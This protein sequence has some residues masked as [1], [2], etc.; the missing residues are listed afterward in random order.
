MV[1]H[2]GS[3]IEKIFRLRIL[4][5]ILLL[6]LIFISIGLFFNYDTGTSFLDGH[7]DNIYQTWKVQ[8]F[9]KN[10]KLVMNDKK[11]QNLRFRVNKDSTADWIRPTNTLTMKLWVTED[12]SKL[13][14]DEGETIDDIETVYELKKDKLR[15]GKRTVMSHYEYVMVPEN[16]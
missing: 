12:G 7:P 3:F 10:G 14:K 13:I 6:I 11:F 2:S 9:Y 1:K 4:L 8:R 5:L 15:F 16:K